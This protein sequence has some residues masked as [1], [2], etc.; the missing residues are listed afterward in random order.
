MHQCLCIDDI[1]RVVFSFIDEH[2]YDPTQGVYVRQEHS[3]RMLSALSRTCH[4]FKDPALDVLWREIPDLFILIKSRIP[5]HL[6]GIKKANL[7]FVSQPSL[8]DWK[9]LD[10][11]IDRIRIIGTPLPFTRPKRLLLHEKTVLQPLE[12]YL[13]EHGPSTEGRSLLPNL[14]EVVWDDRWARSQ[15]IIRNLLMGPSL[16]SLHFTRLH[17]M[18]SLLSQTSAPN[19]LRNLTLHAVSYLTDSH[20]GFA[21]ATILDGLRTFQNLQH[22][23]ITLGL[24]SNDTIAH[25]ASLPTLKSLGI[26]LYLYRIGDVDEANVGPTGNRHGV[27]FSHLRRLSLT[28]DGWYDRPSLPFV[29]RFIDTSTLEAISVTF[30]LQA[31]NRSEAHFLRWLLQCVAPAAPTL[32][33]LSVYTGVARPTWSWYSGRDPDFHFA[34][35]PDLLRFTKLRTLRLEHQRNL[36]PANNDALRAIADAFPDL[37]FLSLAAP[38]VT[39][40]EANLDPEDLP[41]LDGLLPMAERCRDLHTLRL[42]IRSTLIHRD[43][44]LRAASRCAST[45]RTLSLWATPLEVEVEHFAETGYEAVENA[46]RSMSAFTTEDTAMFFREVFPHLDDLRVVI[47]KDDAFGLNRVEDIHGWSDVLDKLA[48][49]EIPGSVTRSRVLE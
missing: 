23:S 27:R 29:E 14:T 36:C 45:I 21:H 41:T 26:H 17:H 33:E 7:F 2:E 15:D 43:E 24:L 9:L 35:F 16:S 6:Q 18:T 28:I 5:S 32:R 25:L 11:Y 37:E 22:I 1:L 19:N 4:T 31:P 40:Y 30:T 46:S 12:Q 47:P 10:P 34:S 39:E 8:E 48:E 3:L 13:R 38:G 49:T 20:L 44:A 42:P